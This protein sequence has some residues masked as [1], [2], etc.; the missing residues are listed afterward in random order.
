MYVSGCREREVDGGKEEVR[1][2]QGDHEQCR[3]VGPELGTAQQ[4]YHGL[5]VAWK[6]RQRGRRNMYSY[7]R[8]RASGSII[9][10]LFFTLRD[11]D[12]K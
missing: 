5:K 1:A 12:E 11:R 6:K 4:R 2:G 10:I 7:K 8:A 9:S 3:R